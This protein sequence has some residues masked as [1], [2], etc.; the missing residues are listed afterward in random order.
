[1][2]GKKVL[3]KGILGILSLV[4]LIFWIYQTTSQKQELSFQP[5]PNE[6]KQN[7]GEE[8]QEDSD[9]EAADDIIMVDVKGAVYHPGVY[10]L[11]PNMRVQ[12]AINL[13]GGLTKNADPFSINLAER[14]YDEMSIIVLEKGE[15]SNALPSSTSSPKIRINKATLEEIESLP[16]IGPKKAEAIIQYRD[17]NGPFKQVE[18][19]LEVSG[20]GEKTLEQ[21]KEYLQIP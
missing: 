15:S 2:K 21:L 18:D 4:I 3:I 8:N 11:L 9:T 6:N 12:D 20:I 1:M 19:L 16:G 10:K 17:E 13:A 5:F 7:S 14:V